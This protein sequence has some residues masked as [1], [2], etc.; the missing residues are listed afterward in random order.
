MMSCP[1]PRR[2]ECLLATQTGTSFE[3][4]S[5]Y[6]RSVTVNFPS[7]SCAPKTRVERS[8]LCATS[9]SRTTANALQGND[10]D[11]QSTLRC[12]SWYLALLLQITNRRSPAGIG[13]RAKS[14]GFIV[15]TKNMLCLRLTVDPR[16]R[17]TV[18]SSVINPLNRVV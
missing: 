13:V 8:L 9:T 16:L 15:I 3:V 18:F 17:Y 10:T 7:E 12:Q 5:S 14:S 11:G 6:F 4:D 2:T 1:R